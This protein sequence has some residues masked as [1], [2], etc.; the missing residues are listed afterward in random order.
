MIKIPVL[1]T[2]RFAYRF[3]FG[4]LG[5]II[6]L[7]WI[8]QLIM[9]VGIY[10]TSKP[11]NAHIIAGDAPAPQ[12]TLL[13][14]AGQVASGLLF[15]V[16]AVA[17]VK[18]ALGLRQGAARAHLSFGMPELRLFCSAI[19]LILLLV[20]FGLALLALASA[21]RLVPGNYGVLL[22]NIVFLV[23]LG[24]LIYAMGRLSFLV[25]PASVA[26]G[27]YG[28][29][30]SWILTRG[31]FWRIVAVALACIGPVSLISMM[32]LLIAVGPDAFPKNLDLSGPNGVA[33]FEAAEARFTAQYQPLILGMSFA[34]APFSFGLA[35]GAVAGVYRK[36]TGDK[37]PA[38][39][40][41]GSIA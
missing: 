30:R 3:A 36:L 33:L 19:A 15:A 22:E 11:F 21:G 41:R 27:D 23:G 7:I 16:M 34:F 35:M 4:Q 6:G 14:L 17:V 38:V 25:V 5:A 13:V 28:I 20:I 1:D 39:V 40:E 10:L 12:D 32:A 9:S 37:T 18:Q 29:E 24:G 26:N 2:I 8:P 31:N